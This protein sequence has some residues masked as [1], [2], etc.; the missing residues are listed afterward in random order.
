MRQQ[1]KG[2][3]GVLRGHGM[4]TDSAWA[5]EIVSVKQTVQL[6]N[7]GATCVALERAGIARL[8]LRHE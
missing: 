8:N 1:R 6:E 2:S 5:L 3:A 4:L 7:I